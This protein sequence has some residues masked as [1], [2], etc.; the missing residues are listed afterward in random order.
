[1]S[2]PRTFRAKV[3]S[4]FN[5]IVTITENKSKGIINYDTDN[6]LPQR[7]A[8]QIA[9]SGTATACIEV[10]NQY[11]YADGL[12]DEVLAKEKANDE[13]TFN[14]LISSAAPY[15]SMYQCIALH[16]QRDGTGTPI[17][18]RALP[19]GKIRVADNGNYIYNPTYSLDCKFDQKQDVEYPKYKGVKITPEDLKSIL[20]YKNNEGKPVGEILYFFR[21]KPEQYTYPIPSY[22]SAISDIDA[23]AEQ[24]KFELESVNNAFLPGGFLTIV[25][26]IDDKTE[27]E[28]GMTEMDH[29]DNIC[30]SF[31]GNAKDNKGETGRNKLM[32]LFA[33]TKEE[34][35]IYQSVNTGEVF[36]AVEQST[37][38]VAKKVARAFGVPDFLIGLGG[39]VG[40][41]TNIISDN[42]TL[43]NNR[44]NPLQN[45]IKEALSLVFP[46]KDFTLTQ[47]IPVKY[48]A[49]EIYAKL[50]DAELR[51]LA[52]YKTEENKTQ[53]TIS[54]AQ[55]LGVGST[56]SL[57]EVIKDPL[58][59][60][61]QKV[62]A[63]VILFNI[64]EEQAKKL[65]I[66]NVIQ[67]TNN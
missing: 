41:S 10:L 33:K 35:P 56:T 28:N 37:P 15:V 60:E 65:V 5:R 58:L 31:T 67:P 44:V 19:F 51:E 47:L 23:D 21:K 50:T 7:I 34:I 12:V 14:Q 11:I 9:E 57:V 17:K 6:L 13:Q 64:P 32:L 54:L 52:G 49:P 45:L 16:V 26:D 8:R 30:E 62:N 3:Y 27:D 43:F 63:L 20:S 46:D 66:K 1:M 53:S 39:S 4:F 61:S 2:K 36:N 29:Y 22:Y 24:S 42:I 38:R 55:T 18:A 40:F 59:D 25:G 48:I